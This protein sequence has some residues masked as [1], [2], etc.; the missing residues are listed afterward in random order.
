VVSST[1]HHVRLPDP[2]ISKGTGSSAPQDSPY[3]K[4]TLSGPTFSG[5][6]DVDQNGGP[7]KIVSH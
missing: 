3:L 2:E 1:S 6:G 5:S 4:A 7:V